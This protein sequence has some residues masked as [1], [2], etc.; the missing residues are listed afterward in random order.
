MRLAHRFTL[1]VAL[2][3]VSVT[4]AACGSDKSTGPGNN[5]PPPETPAS[6]ALHFDTLY[7]SA[8]ASSATDSNYNFRKQALSDIELP[9][10][11]GVLPTTISVTTASGTEQWNGF[12]FEEVTNNGSVVTDSA[13]LILAYRDTAAHTMIAAGFFG[14]GNSL[15]ATLIT[16][17]TVVAHATTN[18]GSA[19]LVSVGGACATPPAALTN[20]IIASASQATCAKATFNAALTLA[21]APKAGVDASLL[22]ISFPSTSFA[23][24]RFQDPLTG[25]AETRVL[26]LMLQR[27]RSAH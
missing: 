16:N 26:S 15:G 8:S 23:G 12:V 1:L 6:I 27:L 9:A 19:S 18:S 24:E 4:A 17:D 13:Y 2:G 14:N 11:F 22:A 25:T 5:E 10:A 3:I 20:P 21:F 7:A